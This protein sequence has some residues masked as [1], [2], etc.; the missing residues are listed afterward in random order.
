MPFST[1]GGRGG[2]RGRGRRE[3]GLGG[4]ESGPL[5][6]RARGAAPGPARYGPARPGA[7]RPGSRQRGAAEPR[8]A[9]APAGSPPVPDRWPCEGSRA[10]GAAPGAGACPR[11]PRRASPVPRRARPAAP[12]C[13]LPGAEGRA[14]RAAAAAGGGHGDTRRWPCRVG[15]LLGSSPPRCR[16]CKGVP[17]FGAVVAC[18][19]KGGGVGPYLGECVLAV[20]LGEGRWSC[21]YAQFLRSI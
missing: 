14:A 5:I 21:A 13:S 10:P 4:G 2:E 9:P 19:R 15:A 17:G 3:T 6:I 1:A 7:P 12:C 11:A 8:M 20:V 18:G 16:L